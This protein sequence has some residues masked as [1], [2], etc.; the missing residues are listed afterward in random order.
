MSRR[1]RRFGLIA[2]PCVIL[3]AGVWGAGI[4]FHWWLTEGEVPESTTTVSK[5]SET[6][7]AD[8][9]ALLRE[10]Q[11][12]FAAVKDYK[13]V[14]LQEEL[15]ERGKQAEWKKNHVLLK[16]RHEPFAVLMEYVSPH[17]GRK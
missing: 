13:C 14:F 3:A 16:V 7:M 17:K 15:F 8:A 9:L 10:A 12:R 4:Y 5:P 6:T 1:L 11:Q 2:L